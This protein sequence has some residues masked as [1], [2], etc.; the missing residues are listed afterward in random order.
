MACCRQ[1]KWFNELAKPMLLAFEQAIF[2]AFTLS[3][4]D[5]IVSSSP[6][7]GELNVYWSAACTMGLILLGW[8]VGRLVVK[9]MAECL[10]PAGFMALSSVD[11]SDKNS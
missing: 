3:V 11:D 1:E 9:L 4:K 5:A 2:F 6:S 8:L 7:W 10:C